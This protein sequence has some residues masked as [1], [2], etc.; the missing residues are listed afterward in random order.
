MYYKVKSISTKGNRL[1]V[2]AAAN[3]VRPITYYKEEYDTKEEDLRKKV[4]SFAISILEGNFQPINSCNR[5]EFWDM[6]KNIY[7]GFDLV[8]TDCIEDMKYG[9]N[10]SAELNELIADMILV[11]IFFHEFIDAAEVKRI[12]TNFDADS[13]FMYEKMAERYKEEGK[14]FVTSAWRCDIIPGTDVVYTL[15]EKW[16][17]CK[18]DHYNNHGLLDNADDTA[19]E[20]DGGNYE[21]RRI[22]LGYDLSK[23]TFDKINKLKERMEVK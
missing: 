7:K 23:E 12:I 16:Y 1:F 6:A 9:L 17:L 14:I 8:N 21:L 15:D 4:K 10:R 22:L 2:T 13:K 18:A 11:P 20:F 5:K 19:I 3:N